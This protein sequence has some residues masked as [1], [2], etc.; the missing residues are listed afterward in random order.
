MEIGTESAPVRPRPQRAAGERWH[1]FTDGELRFV[2]GLLTAEGS[3]D[4]RAARMAEDIV[5]QADERGPYRARFIV[6]EGTPEG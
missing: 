2:Y 1:L 3:D 5:A 6:G 4:R